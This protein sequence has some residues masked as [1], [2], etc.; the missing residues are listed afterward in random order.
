MSACQRR[1]SDVY[2]VVCARADPVFWLMMASERKQRLW[3]VGAAWCIGI[4]LLANAGVW[5]WS[6]FGPPALLSVPAYGQVTAQSA[7]ARGLFLAPAQIGP[8][9]YGCY[10]M[11]VDAGTI[12]V[13]RVDAT[14]NRMRLMS[15]RSFR[16]DRLLED[17][18]NDS[19]TPREVQKLVQQQQARE[20]IEGR[21]KDTPE[22]D[23]KSH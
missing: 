4:G 23:D 19:P 21:R 12:S 13:Y 10:L 9:E 14:T 17:F 5:C 22:G 15:A 16:H 1:I 7:G 20:E 8:R 6:Q 2:G 18:N 3:S 11:D